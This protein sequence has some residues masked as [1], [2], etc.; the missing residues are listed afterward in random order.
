MRKTLSAILA[1]ASTAAAGHAA[2]ASVL[3]DLDPGTTPDTGLSVG[4]GLGRGVLF[5]ANTGFTVD[6]VGVYL[7]PSQTSSFSTDPSVTTDLTLEIRDSSEALVGS[8]SQTLS[9]DDL[10]FYWFDITDYTFV[11]GESY[12]LLLRPTSS[13]LK[14]P[15]EDNLPIYEINGDVA[16][17]SWLTLKSGVK[18]Q[19][20]NPDANTPEAPLFRLS[21]VPEP[22]SIALGLIALGV[23]GRRR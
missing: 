6:A 16:I 19:N 20:G 12:F 18:I 13:D 17:G 22:A 14:L 9:G 5:E 10:E 21:I 15:K 8:L 4:S 2:S 1:A 23:I 11:A 3:L 7:K